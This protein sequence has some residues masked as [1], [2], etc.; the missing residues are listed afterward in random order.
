[1]LEAPVR[2]Q[3]PTLRP[4]ALRVV[5]LRLTPK[6][7]TREAPGRC[8]RQ[9]NRTAKGRALGNAGSSSAPPAARPACPDNGLRCCPAPD[10]M[11]M[12]AGRRAG[13]SDEPNCV[14]LA[15]ARRAA[16]PLEAS[17]FHKLGTALVARNH[18]L[19]CRLW[20]ASSLPASPDARTRSPWGPR[21]RCHG[22][23][24]L[25]ETRVRRMP[26]PSHA[27]RISSGERRALRV[28]AI[29]A[30]SAADSPRG[31]FSWFV[32]SGRQHAAS[33][34]RPPARFAAV[35]HAKAIALAPVTVETIRAQMSATSIACC[36]DSASSVAA[37][38]SAPMS[39]SWQSAFSAA[40]SSVTR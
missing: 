28:F 39:P 2:H 19:P 30:K 11:H 7:A 1:M 5:V 15:T 8:L 22:D 6:T 23:F 34:D 36:G 40:R 16:G 29:C 32:N 38:A 26:S 4:P 21:S 35:D 33:A 18:H 31:R 27:S 10:S 9:S 20:A 3:D 37:R 12:R 14:V 24:S 25:C 13:L 17:E